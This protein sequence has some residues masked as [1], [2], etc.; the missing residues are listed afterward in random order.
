MDQPFLL[1]NHPN[2]WMSRGIGLA[3]LVGVLALMFYLAGPV[4]GQEAG[5]AGAAT[6]KTAA[7]IANAA[8]DQD[9]VPSIWDLFMVS[10]IINGSLAVMSALATV[11]FLYLLLTVTSRNYMPAGFVD[12]V[13]RLVINRQFDQANN[14][15]T[16]NRRI[17]ASSI[18]QR[19]IENRDKD[20]AVILAMQQAEGRR[21][22]E[23]LWSVVGY[24]SEIANIAP[25]V[26]LL[27]TVIGMIKAFFT[28]D[29]RNPSLKSDLLA[30]NIAEAMGTTMFGLIVAITA[31]IYFTIIKNRAT[32][33]LTDVEQTCQT[34]ADHTH[35][36]VLETHNKSYMT[37]GSQGA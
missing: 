37:D 31:G 19:C 9:K 17:F 10:P 21:R 5:N 23:R 30:N 22:A 4:S 32:R 36:A 8:T 13:T 33:V 12:D 18:V 11:I 20:T 34:I 35:R 7:N 2:T 25:M 29:T 1:K 24:I 6:T 26:G 16:N 3:T 27:G 28:L 15:C 14:L